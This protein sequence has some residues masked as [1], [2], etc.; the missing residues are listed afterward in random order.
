[1][2]AT[3]VALSGVSAAHAAT[4][5]LDLTP[6]DRILVL[7][8]H[9]DD[10]VL[11]CGGILQK[12]VA[13]GLPVR[14][15]FM[16]NGDS[17]EWSFLAYRFR[18]TLL[19][20][21]AIN[22]GTLRRV[23]A[24]RAAEVLGVPGADLVFLGYPDYGTLRMWIA[25]WGDRPPERGRLTRATRVPYTTAYRHGAPY[26]G[27]ELLHDLESIVR[28]FRPTKV[29]VSHP[30]DRHP[31]HAALY[32]FTRVALWD[33][34]DDVGPTVHPYLVHYAGWPVKRNAPDLD[35][36]V[37]LAGA[38]TW[39]KSPVSEEERTKKKEAL[40]A[41]RTQYKYSARRLLR[42]VRADE[43]FGEPS[44]IR[45]S[46]A[47]EPGSIAGQD[48]V[49]ESDAVDPEEIPAGAERLPAHLVDVARMRIRDE[50][51][52]LEFTIDLDTPLEDQMLVS[53]LVM[54]YRSDHPFATMPKLEVRFDRASTR[55]FDDGR[56]LPRRSIRVT[57]EGNTIVARVP[58][59][60]LGEPDRL[61]VGTWTLADSM[62]LSRV[63][64]QEIDLVPDAV[65]RRSGDDGVR[66][67][68]AGTNR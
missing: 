14:V 17:N 67:G 61:F 55:V 34:A 28:A 25:R 41:H 37:N 22:M 23:E 1:V 68:G 27:E 9:P 3:L 26:R 24:I 58:L 8:P 65:A 47:S 32:L 30:A 39:E 6:N 63:P 20:S 54:G 48:G 5:G 52:A 50:G 7:A 66:V 40:V 59:N 43:L 10:E 21:S 38:M 13:R 31:D 12:A 19:P 64:W 29:F 60:L 53:L 57:R 44:P 18:P 35:P 51:T 42:F 11:G 33:L 15:V 16:T 49:P 2:L 45:L 36:P 46:P 56:P 62:Q 4:S